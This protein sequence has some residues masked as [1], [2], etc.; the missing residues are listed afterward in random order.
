MVGRHHGQFADGDAVVPVGGR[1]RGRN[2]LGSGDA[3][4]RIGEVGEDGAVQ[5]D[6]GVAVLDKMG[7][8]LMSDA[9]GG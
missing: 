8:N 9:S 7:P 3:V 6:D 1:F 5:V 4:L 2:S